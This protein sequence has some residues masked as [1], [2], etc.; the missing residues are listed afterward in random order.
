VVTSMNQ[1]HLAN[2][3]PNDRFEQQEMD[4]HHVEEM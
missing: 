2:D 4:V 3:N 1:R